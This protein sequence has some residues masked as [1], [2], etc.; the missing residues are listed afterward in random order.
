MY[1]SGIPIL[2]LVLFL[3]FS[4]CL[5]VLITKTDKVFHIHIWC[6]EVDKKGTYKKANKSVNVWNTI[7]IF[8]LKILPKSKSGVLI[9]KEE[10]MD[11]LEFHCLT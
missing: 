4:F 11:K 8:V 1:H 10:P 7:P 2:P 3:S 6:E 9:G 5:I